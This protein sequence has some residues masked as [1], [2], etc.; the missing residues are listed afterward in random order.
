[1]AP[2][3]Q[4]STVYFGRNIGAVEGVSEKDWRSFLKASVTPKFPKG[5]TVVDGLGQYE[6]D[7]NN[8]IRER[9][10]ILILVHPIDEKS[11]NKVKGLI[12]RYKAQFKQESVLWVEASSR[13]N[14]R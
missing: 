8:L 11:R 12:D 2:G 14:F 1:M 9:S 7:K 3:W 10:K 13:V 6:D 4:T 5:L